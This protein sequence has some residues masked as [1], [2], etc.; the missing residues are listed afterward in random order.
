MRRMSN[1]YEQYNGMK[2]VADVLKNVYPR[3]ILCI[4]L[5]R[6]YSGGSRSV[7]Y[8]DGWRL[9]HQ[10]LLYGTVVHADDVDT[11]PWG[12]QLLPVQ[13]VTPGGL[14][15]GGVDSVNGR[16]VIGLDGTYAGIDVL[17]RFGIEQ[18]GYHLQFRLVLDDGV[19]TNVC[20]VA[21]GLR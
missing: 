10:H 9:L 5:G 13:T 3:P 1:N 17:T 12:I 20:R 16:G 2:S 18:H 15:A 8:G 19:E 21:V 11:T 7:F 6:I 14:L 4:L